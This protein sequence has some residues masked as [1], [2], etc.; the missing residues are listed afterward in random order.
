[1]GYTSYHVEKERRKGEREGKV[2]I[3]SEKFM[4]I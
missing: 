4:N 1:M 2:K 3:N